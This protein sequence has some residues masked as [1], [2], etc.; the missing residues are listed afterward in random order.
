[1]PDALARCV[2]DVE[3]FLAGTFTVAPHL[4]RGARFDDLLSLADVDAQLSGAGIRRPAVRVVRDG[5]PVDPARWT[6]RARSGRTW[7]D[8]LVHPA[9]L[10]GL[11]EEG[12]TIVLQSLHRWWP[13]LTRFCRDLELALGHAVQANAYLTPPGAAGL[14]PHHD[15]HDV[16][17]LQSHGTKHWCVR[18]P[19]VEAPLGRHGSDHAEAAGR[20]VLFEVDL[21]PG[22]CLYLPRGFVH[23]ATTQDG[24]SLHLTIGVLATTRHDL[25]R[26]VVDRV[27]EDPV[28]R[29]SLPVGHAGGI[30]EAERVVKDVVADLVRWLEGL[31]TAEVATRMVDREL[32]RRLPLLDGHLVDLTRLEGI[33]DRTRVVV[34]HGLAWRLDAGGSRSTLVLPDR[35]IDLP[36]A[37]DAAVLRLLAGKA[38]PVGALDDLLDGPSRRVL[39]RRLVREGALRIVD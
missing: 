22:D 32:G 7:I 27:A 19:A 28:F 23:S 5:Q 9:R 31:D 25:V 39:V 36:A 3:E 29:R 18:E 13:P 14:V 6:R 34:R 21:G 1:M 38:L 37:V 35:R 30:E 11:F 2:G 24:P 26:T 15:T 12:A 33:D 4:R 16:F 8:D 17:V 10:F 20:P